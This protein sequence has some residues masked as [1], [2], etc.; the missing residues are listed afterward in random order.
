MA[1]WL[2]DVAQWRIGKVLYLSVPFTWL[3]PRARRL[4]KAHN[5]PVQAGGPA[6]ML[7]P[8]YLAG[9]ATVNQPCPVEPLVMHNPLA[10]FTTRGCPNICSFCAV[11][12]L[13]GDLKELP[14]WRPAP[15]ICDNNLLAASRRHFNRVV[16]SLKGLPWVDFN[17]GLEAG[18]LKPWHVRRLAELKHVKIRFSFDSLE[19]ESSVAEAIALCQRNGLNDI[20]VYVLI[21][22]DDTPIDAQY[23]L[24]MVHQ[25]GAM[26]N[27]MRFQPLNAVEKDQFIGVGWTDGLL[28]KYMRWYSRSQWFGT[29]PIDCYR[30][31]DTGPTLF[32]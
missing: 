3:L 1:D 17:Q 13:E 10:T 31:M 2:K 9:V 11:S 18:R 16:D 30:A 28:K 21:G 25:W 22:Y 4:A 27:P 29:R 19:E 7:M 32:D 14:S 15:L 23:R 26:T 6:V 8:D 24:D 12:R 5:G 20:S